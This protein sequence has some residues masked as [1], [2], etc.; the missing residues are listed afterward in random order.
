MSS[1]T[2]FFYGLFMDPDILRRQGYQP[3]APTVAKLNNYAIY[4]GKRATLL[5]SDGEQAYGTLMRLSNSEL[6]E[7]YSQPSVHDYQAVNVTCELRED[8]FI[9]ATTYI[10][11]ED[12]LLAPPLNADYARQLLNIC[13]KMNLPS[14]YQQKIAD[15]KL[16]LENQTK[17]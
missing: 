3:S 6:D 13:K 16:S 8:D 7:L 11:P 2:I 5:P 1:K 10:L 17:K 12:F 4:L 9:E 15:I 14:H